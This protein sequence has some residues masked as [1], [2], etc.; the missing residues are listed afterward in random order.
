MKLLFLFLFFCSNCF[1][2]SFDWLSHINFSKKRD[3]VCAYYEKDYDEALAHFH[4][5][6]HK[7]PYDAELNYNVGDVLYRQN[8]YH[9][10]QAAFF[11]AADQAKSLSKL[12]EQALFNAG[13]SSYQI[14]EWLQAVQAF[15]QV[16]KINEKN[17]SARHNLQL[18][19]YKLKEQQMQDKLQ[20][21]K[22]EKQEEKQ[23]EKNKQKNNPCDKNKDQKAQ[24]KNQSQDPD[25]DGQPDDGADN[26]TGQGQSSPDKPGKK[27]KGSQ[28][29]GQSQQQ[30]GGKEQGDLGD[31]GDDTLKDD[32]S[33]NEDQQAKDGQASSQQGKQLDQAEKLNE[34]GKEGYSG[35]DQIG[36]QDKNGKENGFEKTDKLDNQI[37][38]D[39]Q[40]GDKGNEN[41]L[42][43]HQD[44][45]GEEKSQDVSDGKNNKKVDKKQ[46]LKNPLQE[47]LEFKASD[48]NRLNAYHAKL[49]EELENYEEQIQKHSIKNKVAMQ[50]VGQNG[51]KGW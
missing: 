15:E 20:D 47:E 46:Q 14:E 44:K 19:L 42:A 10:A 34:S 41:S 29:N 23:Q 32:G 21:D 35:A 39:D 11:R 37:S 50:G 13:N 1:A 16:L 9:D 51:K 22:Q 3:A 33:G 25:T 30:Q 38:N 17:E 43:D 12:Q 24:D 18:A 48:D 4:D 5:L 40:S 36:N 8:K 7:N 27:D 45:A 26:E 28:K 49:M 6:M 2:G 31:D